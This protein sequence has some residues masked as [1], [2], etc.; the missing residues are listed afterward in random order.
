M[1]V[2]NNLEINIFYEEEQGNKSDWRSLR[3]KKKKKMGRETLKKV[4]TDKSCKEFAVR[5]DHKWS[6]RKWSPE[7]FFIFIISEK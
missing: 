4:R 3:K 1:E 6:I 7:K 5:K 2:I